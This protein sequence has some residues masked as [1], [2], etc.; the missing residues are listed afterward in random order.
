M[1]A[2]RLLM[3]RRR[4]KAATQNSSTMSQSPIKLIVGLGNPGEKY[5]KTRHNAGFLFLDALCERLSST[6]KADKHCFGRTAKV[7]ISDSDIRLLAPDTFMN[8][9]GK[10]VRAATHYYKVAMSEVL[11]VHDELDLD[12]GVARLKIGGGHGGNN[13]LRDIIQQSGTKEFARL[14]IGIGHPGVGRDVS[15]YVLKSANKA[16]QQNI[17]NAIAESL[18]VIELIAQGDFPRAMNELHT[19]LAS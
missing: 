12:T 19:N 14:R 6:L 17:D 2:K 15:G 3:A 8:L 16:D 7:S 18:R 9:S 11:V 4:K 10:A 1:K 5:A 13:G